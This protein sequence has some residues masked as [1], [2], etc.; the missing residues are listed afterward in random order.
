RV[1]A[2]AG[3]PYVKLYQQE[4]ERPVVLLLDLN[5]GMFFGTRG[6][7]KSVVGAR[8]AA[9]IGWAATASGD[10]VGAQLFNGGHRE[11]QPRGGR[12]GALR[13]I[14]SLVQA[15]DL[16]RGMQAAPHPDALNGAL[17]RLRRVARPGSLVFVISD[18]YVIDDETRKHLLRL[19]RHADAIA[20]QVVDPLELAAPPPGRYGITDGAEKGILDTRV[21]LEQAA[22]SQWFTRHHEQVRRL[23]QSVAIPLLQISTTDDVASVLR[24]FLANPHRANPQTNVEGADTSEAA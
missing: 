8:I 13:L 12:P 14:R 21:R 19:R 9:L 20:V 3:H 1:T 6:A 24:V 17:Q 18:F 15:T 23:M 7:F 16:E 10:R 11:I 4:R 2:R 5:P 22:Y